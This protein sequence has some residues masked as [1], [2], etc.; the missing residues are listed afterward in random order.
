MIKVAYVLKELARQ[1]RI[2]ERLHPITMDRHQ[3]K[4]EQA[5]VG[6]RHKQELV[7]KMLTHGEII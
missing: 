5:D 1:T 7:K 4:R 6:E 3:E 2:G